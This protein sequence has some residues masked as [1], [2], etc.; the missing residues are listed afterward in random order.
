MSEMLFERTPAECY[1]AVRRLLDDEK[2]HRL[3]MVERHPD[4]RDYWLT[5]VSSVEQATGALERLA[6]AAGVEP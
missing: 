5:R 3:R 1:F 2:D 6:A 4:K